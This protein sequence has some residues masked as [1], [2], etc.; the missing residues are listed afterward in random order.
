MLII[1]GVIITIIIIG[2]VKQ[3]NAKINAAID[4]YVPG[5]ACINKKNMR[6]N[7]KIIKQIYRSN[8]R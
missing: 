4:I 3:H 6:L 8:K 1:I 5:H 2:K 7:K